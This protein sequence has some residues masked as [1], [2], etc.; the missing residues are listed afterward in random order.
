MD[1]E[2]T[3]EFIVENLA[4]LTVSQQE[5]AARQEKAEARQ[6]KAEAR[7]DRMDRQ[8]HGLQNI[9]KTGM[10][11][12]VKL[13]RSLVEL[14]AAQKRTEQALAELATAQKRTDLKFDRWLDSLKGTNGHKK[15]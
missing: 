5:W 3:M 9:V 12:I 6:Q 13:D 8:I 7:A 15:R 4:A 2:R 14:A 1:L 11:M 10:K